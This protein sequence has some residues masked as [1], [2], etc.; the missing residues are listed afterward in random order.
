MFG[1]L[2]VSLAEEQVRD[3]LVLFR[4]EGRVVQLQVHPEAGRGLGTGRV[5]G[6]PQRLQKHLRPLLK[7]VTRLRHIS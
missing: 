1:P 4:Q 5:A 3:R 6:R 2:Q 7:Q